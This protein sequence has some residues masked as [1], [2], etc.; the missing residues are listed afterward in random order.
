MFNTEQLT[1]NLLGVPDVT[2]SKRG[3]RPVHH[4]HSDAMAIIAQVG[5][6]KVHRVLVDNGSVVNIIFQSALERMGLD[7]EELQLV[8]TLFYGFTRDHLMPRGMISL[9]VTLGDHC[10]ITKMTDLV[11]VN[12]PSTFNIIVG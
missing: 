3:A 1:L 6:N 8:T 11:V 12:Y 4:S 10:E 9:P 2:F 5:N 7:G